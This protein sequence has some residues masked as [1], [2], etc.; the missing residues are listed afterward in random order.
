MN[1]IPAA[2]G[3]SASL[4]VARH[5]DEICVRFERAWMAGERPAIEEYLGDTGEPAR[6]RLLGELVA[7]EVSCRRRRGETVQADEYQQRFPNLDTAALAGLC[8]TLVPEAPGTRIGPYKLLQQLGEGGMGVV[9][10]A[11]QEEP[12]RRQVALKVI[13]AGL[14]SARVLARFEQER[15]AL[16]LMDHPISPKCSTPAARRRAGLTSSWNWSRDCPSPSTAIRNG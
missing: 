6:S 14:D 13:K 8:E 15:Q 5:V 16:A 11:E 7:V 4:A 3:D 10:L 1:D 12:V 2:P 9:F